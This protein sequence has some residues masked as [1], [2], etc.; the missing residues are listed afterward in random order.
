MV[1]FSFSGLIDLEIIYMMM[2]Q[3]QVLYQKK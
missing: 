1:Q 3:N 2:I